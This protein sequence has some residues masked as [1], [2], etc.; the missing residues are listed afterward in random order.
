MPNQRQR[1]EKRLK[2]LME[3]QMRDTDL[4]KEIFAAS[5]DALPP[6]D[7]AIV[8]ATSMARDLRTHHPATW[9]KLDAELRVKGMQ[10]GLPI[11]GD[12][13]CL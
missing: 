1:R 4:F 2:D 9:T 8:K 10:Y 13:L 7:Q 12:D 6:T 3:Q 11:C 5:V